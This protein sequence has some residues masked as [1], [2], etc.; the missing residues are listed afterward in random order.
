MSPPPFPLPVRRCGGRVPTRARTPLP[1]PRPRRGLRRPHHRPGLG[2]RGPGLQRVPLAPAARAFQKDVTRDGGGGG[3]G[4]GGRCG[5][6]GAEAAP[7]AGP[8]VPLVHRSTGP[9]GPRSLG[10]G[11]T[12]PRRAGPGG[13]CPGVVLCA[14]PPPAPNGPLGDGAAVRLVGPPVIPRVGAH[15]AGPPRRRWRCCGRWVCRTDEGGRRFRS[16]GRTDGTGSRCGGPRG[17]CEAPPE[18]AVMCGRS[19]L[20]HTAPRRHEAAPPPPP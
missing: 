10:S 11:P 8:S 15:A 19:D 7:P 18:G 14:P 16:D 3:G 20:R 6:T 2:G 4:G 13:V 9:L 1:Q 12:A 5:C 17:T